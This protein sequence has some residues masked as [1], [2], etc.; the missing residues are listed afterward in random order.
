MKFESDWKAFGAVGALW[1]MMAVA[2]LLAPGP[3]VSFK[4]PHAAARPLEKADAR[5]A[6]ISKPLAQGPAALQAQLQT[7]ADRYRDRVGIA[8]ID[9]PNNWEVSV[10]GSEAFPQQSVSK[11]WVAIAVLDAVDRGA[12]RLNTPVLMLRSDLSVFFQ[13][14]ARK[15]GPMGY[16]TTVADLL[17]RAISDS[18]NAAND[19]LIRML[20]GP[21]AVTAVLRRKGLAG[22]RLGYEERVLQAKTAGMEWKPEYAGSPLFREVR[23]ALPDSVRDNAMAAYLADPPDSATPDGMAEG[24]ARLDRGELLKP[25]STRRL[26]EIMASTRNGPRRLKGGLPDGW[27]ISHK[28]GTGQDLRNYSVGINDVGVIT[29]P[30]GHGYA[31]AVFIAKTSHG[32]PARLAFMQ[33]VTHALVDIWAGRRQAHNTAVTVSAAEA[34]SEGDGSAATPSAAATSPAPL[35]HRAHRQA[36]SVRPKRRHSRRGHRR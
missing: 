16:M 10:R 35:A 1:A 2:P 7:L 5:S 12:L 31:V 19:K 28:T 27:S 8:I 9:I 22:V 17:Q 14:I 34:A 25:E 21:Q 32:I 15:V 13:P 33:E 26:L 29:A 18:D 36:D 20:G 3:S 24:L 23:A 11:F 30:D 4:T 6:P